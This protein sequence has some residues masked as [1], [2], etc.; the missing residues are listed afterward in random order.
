MA[1]ITFPRPTVPDEVWELRLLGR[2]LGTYT[3]WTPEDDNLIYYGFVP[4]IG[5]PWPG[6]KDVVVCVNIEHGRIYQLHPDNNAVLLDIDLVQLVQQLP[7]V[8]GE[9][10]AGN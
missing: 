4:A 8:I 5:V 6:P 7:P 2:S 3:D 9:D 1:V 10:D